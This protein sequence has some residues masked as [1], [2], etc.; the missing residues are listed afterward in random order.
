[1]RDAP[2]GP[3]RAYSPKEIYAAGE[4]VEHPKFGL[5]KVA[6]A[7]GGKIEVRFDSGSRLLMHAG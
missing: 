7:R 1:L 3:A 4:W 2:T 6:L 5:G